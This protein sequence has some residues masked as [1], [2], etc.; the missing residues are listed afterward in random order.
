MRL[1][2]VA[3]GLGFAPTDARRGS[4]DGRAIDERLCALADTG[5]P[6]FRLASPASARVPYEE[7]ETRLL[8]GVDGSEGRGTVDFDASDNVFNLVSCRS[9]AISANDLT[10]LLLTIGCRACA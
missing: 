10:D 4:A 5:I 3:L 6:L 1:V 2:D 7:S 9:A 8:D